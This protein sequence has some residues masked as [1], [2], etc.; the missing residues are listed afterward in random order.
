MIATPVDIVVS[1]AAHRDLIARLTRREIEARYRGSAL[2]VLWAVVAPL[3]TMAVY[4]FVF[5]VVLS[6]RWP[7]SPST[8]ETALIILSGLLLFQL[9]SEPFSRAPTLITENPSYVKKVVFPLETLAVVSV[10]V[11]IFNFL[12]GLLV[13]VGFQTALLR[14]PTLALA[15]TPVIVAPLVLMSLGVVWATASIGVFL[16][17]IK[18][19]T[20]VVTTAL[21]F[22]SPIVYPAEAMPERFRW[23]MD[24]NP[25]AG[26]LADF[27][28]A[29]LDGAWPDPVT[30]AARFCAG[31]AVA[32]VGFAWFE[33]TKKAFSDVL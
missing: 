7:N 22:M 23:L 28:G 20:G 24:L 16:R 21:L 12:V 8:E 14:P 26:I 4:A 17:D 31:A 19:I 32:W 2:G 29:L 13:L 3:L 33:R 18:Q 10:L 27:R 9:F 5:S 30:T 6:A 25:M 15:A 11:S 1:A